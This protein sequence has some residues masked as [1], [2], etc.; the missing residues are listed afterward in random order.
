MARGRSH[1]S[2]TSKV[3]FLKDKPSNKNKGNMPKKE[4]TA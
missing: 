4:Y 3:T 2:N 1:L